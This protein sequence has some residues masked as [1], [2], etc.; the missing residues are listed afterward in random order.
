MRVS[1][2]WKKRA[3]P[4]QIKCALSL[5]RTPR[6]QTTPHQQLQDCRHRRRNEHSRLVERR[7]P[8]EGRRTRSGP[9]GSSTTSG[10]Q[11]DQR[12]PHL[13]NLHQPVA[14]HLRAPE[15]A[16]H[17]RGHLSKVQ[18][19]GKRSSLSKGKSGWKADYRFFFSLVGLS[20]TI[21]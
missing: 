4:N 2:V 18:L 6:T 15:R 1:L 19:S 3:Q 8:R 10:W 16:Q 5:I 12:L 21:Q 7:D 13:R 14:E 20:G 9:G 11:K 17:P